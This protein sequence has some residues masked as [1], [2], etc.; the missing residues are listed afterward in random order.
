MSEYTATHMSDHD[1]M[2]LVRRAPG[3]ELLLTVPILERIRPIEGW[4]TDAE[5]DVLISAAAHVCVTFPPDHAIVEI[6]SYEGRS[7]VALASVTALLA[8]SVRVHAIDPHEGEVGAADLGV[9][10]TPAT[11]ARFRENLLRTGIAKQ[12]VICRRRSYET[13]WKEPI[14]L[15]LVDG[16]HD[17]EN[18]ARD[19]HHF[20][21]Y[22]AIGGLV[23]FH[24]YGDWPGVTSFVGHLLAT[25][26]F[27]R[28]AQGGSMILLRWSPVND[29]LAR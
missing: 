14:S 19:F 1:T 10:H 3:G 2:R 9:E 18:C 24:D 13:D 4:L 15:L 7:T 26:G 20:Q 25:P 22:L 28:L 8:P 6:G 12:V 29:L 5:A 21:P 17:Y 27:S 11:L 16:L 23:A